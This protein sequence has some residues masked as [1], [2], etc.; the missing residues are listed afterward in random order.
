L[1]GTARTTANVHAITHNKT[2]TTTGTHM[3]FENNSRKARAHI[4]T[5]FVGSNT[6]NFGANNV[7]DNINAIVKSQGFDTCRCA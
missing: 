3:G 6:V 4:I 2:T 7:V 1:V 5:T